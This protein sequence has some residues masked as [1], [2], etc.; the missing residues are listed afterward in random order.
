MSSFLVSLN[1]R[2]IAKH[3]LSVIRPELEERA[4]TKDKG[5]LTV[6]DVADVLR[7]SEAVHSHPVLKRVTPTDPKKLRELS[8]NIIVALKYD[9]S[10]EADDP[11]QHWTD[12]SKHAVFTLVSFSKYCLNNL[13]P[14]LEASLDGTPQEFS[15]EFKALLAVP[16]VPHEKLLHEIVGKLQESVPE[17]TK[18]KF[19][20]NLREII[21]RPLPDDI[22]NTEALNEWTKQWLNE[23]EGV[24]S[25]LI[26]ELPDEVKPFFQE[27]FKALIQKEVTELMKEGVIAPPKSSNPQ[28]ML[29][30]VLANIDDPEL[31]AQIQR[32]FNSSGMLSPL[33][34]MMSSDPESIPLFQ[35]QEPSVRGSGTPKG[36]PGWNNGYGQWIMGLGGVAL[37]LGSYLFKEEK[38]KGLLFGLGTFGLGGA[39]ASAF[40]PFRNIFGVNSKGGPSVGGWGDG[41]GKWV[42]GGAS[43]VLSLIGYYVSDEKLKTFMLGLGSFGIGGV[44]ASSFNSVRK[45]FGFGESSS[46]LPTDIIGA[47][48]EGYMPNGSR[49]VPPPGLQSRTN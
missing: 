35:G 29:H 38:G 14:L 30:S 4:E 49:N 7:K 10:R 17:F 48:F 3:Y 33:L 16:Q 19:L 13:Y 46:A 45:L 37:S 36:T 23:L 47:L 8:S 12:V 24:F 6:D 1:N 21:D 41:L 31:V 27:K 43:A 15:T 11:D 9:V 28:Q 26:I 5:Q 34:Q 32:Q 39:L 44:L 22:N 2:F 20:Q 25:D 42:V 40:K 18:A